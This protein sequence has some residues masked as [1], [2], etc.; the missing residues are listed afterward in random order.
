MPSKRTRRLPDLNKSQDKESN[1]VKEA[2]FEL[3]E[4]QPEITE[5]T[6][7]SEPSLQEEALVLKEEP[8]EEA[9]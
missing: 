7:V 2:L 1:L 8:P 4:K 5:E 9:K 3:K 6:P